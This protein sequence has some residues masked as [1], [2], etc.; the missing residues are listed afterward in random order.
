MRPHYCMETSTHNFSTIRF[1]LP[2]LSRRVSTHFIADHRG[3]GEP[4]LDPVTASPYLIP[5]CRDPLF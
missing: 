3:P 2:Q 5:F 4:V 1:S